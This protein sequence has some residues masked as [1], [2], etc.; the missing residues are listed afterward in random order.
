MTETTGA[1]HA[2]HVDVSLWY[3]LSGGRSDELDPDEREFA[4][5]RWWTRTE[6]IAADP[7]FMEPHLVR[8]L[9][10]ID[11]ARRRVAQQPLG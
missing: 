7:R 6:V 11:T 4:A 9:A 3:L 8:F 5:V 1:V 2:R 10:K